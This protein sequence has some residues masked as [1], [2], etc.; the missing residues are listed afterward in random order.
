MPALDPPRPLD[1]EQLGD[2]HEVLLRIIDDVVVEAAGGATGQT[3]P[4]LLLNLLDEMTEHFSA[5][6]ALMRAAR[7]PAEEAH[8][9]EHDR[10]LGHLAKL[11]SSHTEGSRF[12]T[13]EVAQTLR[14]VIEHHTMTWD[15]E[16]AQYLR[17]SRNPERR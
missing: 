10:L 14:P 8:S 4:D 12:V 6:Q 13:L 3:V 9:T 11:L 16:L 5:E 17:S 2:A 7:Y 1:P 15:W